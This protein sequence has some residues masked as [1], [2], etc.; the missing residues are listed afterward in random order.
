MSGAG[1]VPSGFDCS[2]FISYAVN[3][4]GAGFH[5]GRQT[6]ESWRRQCT[7][8]PASQAR[9]GDLIF[10]Q[11]TYNTS[12]ASHVGILSGRREND[13]CR[14]PRENQQHQHRLLAAAFL[15]L[16]QKSPVCSQGFQTKKGDYY[17]CT[18]R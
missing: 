13:S 2:G 9:P 6:A 5:F 16:W 11:G 7:I 15:L 4:C 3:N 12:G 18:T 10:F 8:I 14:K 1:T 17:E